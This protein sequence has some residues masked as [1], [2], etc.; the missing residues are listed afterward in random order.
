MGIF[1]GFKKAAMTEAIGLPSGERIDRESGDA[2][3]L[4]A[5]E[6]ALVL[7]GWDAKRRMAEAKSDLERVN[8]RL[9][10]VFGEGVTLEV[11]GH[12]AVGLKSGAESWRITDA[13]TL[14]EALGDRFDDMV[15]QETK[16][17][18]TDMLIAAGLDGDDPA[19]SAVAAALVLNVGK[20]SAAWR[21]A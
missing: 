9:L 13:A 16:Y 20:P 11:G 14:R 21:A 7:E 5:P 1:D 15:F 4:T 3:P 12:C 2:R 8:A 18:P 19:Q 10:E 17:T 6:V